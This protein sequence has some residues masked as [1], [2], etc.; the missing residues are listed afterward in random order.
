M[1]KHKTEQRSNSTKVAAL[2]LLKSGVRPIQ[3][4]RELSIPTRTLRDWRKA[5]MAS[6]NWNG[7]AGDNN[8]VVARP[9]PRKEDPGTRTG[10]R[11]ITDSIKKK[12]KR[13]LEASPFLTPRSLQLAIP[14]LCDVSL[15]CIRHVI[16]GELGIASRLAA[17][18][19]FLTDA[20]KEHR[21]SWP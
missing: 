6:G 11:K 5:S 4:S 2:T 13:K 17:K 9:S 20:Q 16:S 1:P 10:S 15:S 3:V 19:P 12:I 18:K 7:G 14:K 21:L 8:N